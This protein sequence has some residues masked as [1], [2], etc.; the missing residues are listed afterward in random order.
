[1]KI[2]L[3]GA[4]SFVFGPSVLHDALLAHRLPDLELAL[5]D[6]NK[7]MAELMAGLGRQMAA[8]VGSNAKITAHS[9]WTEALDGADFVICSA[10]VQLHKRFA[11]DLEI[12]KRHSPS[13]VV[14][15]FGGIQGISYS[16]RQIAL[17]R[18]LAADMVRQ[19]PKAW[20]LCSSNPLPRICQ[21][22]H[23]LGIQTA[24]FCCNSM[25]GYG[26]VGQLM[27]GQAEHYPWPMA[28]SKFKIVSAG[29][30][31]FTFV[32]KLIDQ[33]TGKDTLPEFIAR[34]Q[35][36]GLM[37][38]RTSELATQTGYWPPNGD[39]HM[40][41]FLPPDGSYKGLQSTSH[42][43][44]SERDA[45]LAELRKAA[46]GE[47]PWDGL[48][49]HRAWEKP[50]DLIAAMAGVWTQE[51]HSLNL[52]NVGQIPNLPKGVFVETPATANSSGP[53]GQTITLPDPVAQVSEP[54][55]K[56][57]DLIVKAALERRRDLV[58]AAVDSD[59][60]ITDK[61]GA[62]AAIDE[63]LLA[64]ADLIGAF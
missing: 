36:S 54:V 55:A 7:E 61:T 51:F 44:A 59:P 11:T 47:G 32:L 52:V 42:G 34:A 14:T 57:T 27:W 62:R 21:A 4:G 56:L 23:E 37:R 48:L 60:T 16:L 49:R 9:A 63:C 8:S 3:I 25:G 45:R 13:H 22:S 31:H 58:H 2:C 10:A 20:L 38:K 41:D 29:V 64:H 35:S 43:S 24:G 40:C 5:I 18:S 17:I 26:L 30:N 12:I 1:M 39:E 6:P 53:V 50:V 46:A 19:C 33:A 15:E 28:T